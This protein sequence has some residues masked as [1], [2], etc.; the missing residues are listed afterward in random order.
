MAKR[1][2]DYRDQ[3]VFLLTP[4]RAESDAEFKVLRTDDGKID[5]VGSRGR[6]NLKDVLDVR[7]KTH[8]TFDP[9]TWRVTEICC[10]D[11]RGKTEAR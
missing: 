8:E 9:S 1:R 7:T 3:V 4:E 2:R 5:K 10:C 11:R 6:M